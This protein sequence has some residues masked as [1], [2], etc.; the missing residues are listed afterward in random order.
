M[1]FAKLCLTPC[2]SMNR[3]PPGSSVRGILQARL[4][5]WVAIPFSWGIFLTQWSNPGSPAL[6]GDSLP[7]P[8]KPHN[9]LKSSLIP[10]LY[11]C[12][13]FMVVHCVNFLGLPQYSPTNWVASNNRS[14]SLTVWKAT[15]VISMCQQRL[16][17]L[18]EILGRTLPHLFPVSGG[19]HQDWCP[20][21]LSH[22]AAICASVVTCMCECVCL[23]VCLL[24]GLF[25]LL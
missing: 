4:L 6:Q 23:S 11:K 9:S 16:N 8:G 7:P 19:N 18:S 21:A 10:K 12:L 13:N 24:N 1:L 2:D 15:A 25:F 5:E 17:A 14:S 20:L 22:I 3:S